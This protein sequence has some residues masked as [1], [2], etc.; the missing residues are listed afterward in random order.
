MIKN[1]YKRENS[2]DLLKFICMIGIILVHLTGRGGL[3][4]PTN[5]N[6]ITYN[7]YLLFN[8]ILRISVNIFCIITGY[9]YITKKNIKTKNI[10][11]IIINVLLYSSIIVLI[12][13]TFNLFNVRN[14]GKLYL[15]N[16]IFPSMIGRYW[17]ITCYFFLF[18]MI[19]YINYFLSKLTK[20]QFKLLLIILFILL[21]II[22]ELFCYD[23]FRIE[24]GYSPFWLIFMYMVG[25]YI[26]IYNI[27]I[28]SKNEI[29][30]MIIITLINSIVVILTKNLLNISSL[31]YYL[32]TNYNSPLMLISSILFFD[33]M[34]KV[35]IGNNFIC[36]LGKYSLAV[37]I[38]HCHRLVYDWI[39]K[40][41][42]LFIKPYNFAIEVLVLI[43]IAILIYLVCSFIEF[44]RLKVFKL[45][46][47]DEL[48]EHFGNKMDEVLSWK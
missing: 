15:L 36:K 21:C 32:G 29:I 48:E 4:N 41:R 47:V 13:Y 35:E 37:Y 38:I 7:F 45:I 26:K 43:G 33:L 16:S 39:I 46:K 44:V 5:N 6:F 18:F 30:S 12:F 40:E 25:A 34:R 9:L 3:I 11:N 10:I 1:N 31:Y 23:Y 42:M 8:N 22:P 14:L 28:T 17:F 20:E 19:P 27:N 2:I 24:N